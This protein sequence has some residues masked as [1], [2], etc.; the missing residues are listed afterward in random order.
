MTGLESPFGVQRRGGVF[1]SP[2]LALSLVLLGPPAGAAG[3]EARTAVVADT[4]RV[5]DV[6][7]VAVRVI[8]DRGE[9]VAWPDTLPLAGDE[10]ENAARVRERVDTLPDGRLQVTATY[11]VTPW[12]TGEMLLPEVPFDVVTGREI[13]RSVTAALPALEVLSVLPADTAGIEPKPLKDVI[14]R[15]WAWWPFLLALLALIALIGGILWWRRRRSGGDEAIPLEPPVPP[16]ER[17]LARLE[18]ART[19]GLVERG[20]MKAFYSQV[21]EAL[22]DYL[23][24]IGAGWGEDLTTTELLARFRAQIGP[25][26]AGALGR[27]LRSADQ[28]KFAR[29]E[30]DPDT[31]MQEWEAA[32]SWVLAFQWP[33]RS[34]AGEHGEAA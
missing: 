18:A 20:E 32:R 25:E 24:A 31:A 2:V 22:R 16:R 28:V 12:R 26:E 5:G 23:A 19:A 1:V 15:S 9:R 14:G 10:I 17:V 30:P 6:V 33:H 11:A 29:R 21:S 7:P 4:I 13:T 27:V 3:Q 34:A 8:V